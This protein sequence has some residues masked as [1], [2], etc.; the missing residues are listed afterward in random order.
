[1]F[2]ASPARAKHDERVAADEEAHIRASGAAL[3]VTSVGRVAIPGN[4]FLGFEAS[5]PASYVDTDP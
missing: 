4:G 2:T 3:S 5:S 1:M